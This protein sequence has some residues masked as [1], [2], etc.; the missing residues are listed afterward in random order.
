MCFILKHLY[1]LDP[2]KN[3]PSCTLIHCQ[4]KSIKNIRS[5][6][7]KSCLL[8]LRKGLLGPIFCRERIFRGINSNFLSCKT[9]IFFFMDSY[10]VKLKLVKIWKE[11]VHYKCV[12]IKHKVAGF[13][14]RTD[15]YLP[16]LHSESPAESLCNFRVYFLTLIMIR[17]LKYFYQ[18]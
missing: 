3:L 5:F 14:Y 13:S 11:S 8:G 15:S 4:L 6:N 1:W 12:K 9:I 7:L 10:R 17:S 16:P 2:Y 18:L